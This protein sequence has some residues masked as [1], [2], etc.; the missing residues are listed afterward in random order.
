MGALDGRVAIGRIRLRRQYGGTV[1]LF[2]ST[3]APIG[4]RPAVPPA[5]AIDHSSR[6]EI[7][8]SGQL[9]TADRAA[10]T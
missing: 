7:A 4:P 10:S 3:E 1:Q 6:S 8:C 5:V 9:S 2:Q